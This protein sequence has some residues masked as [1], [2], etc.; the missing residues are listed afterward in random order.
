MLKHL[1]RLRLPR[2]FP[3]GGAPSGS[4]IS[5]IF[6]F[7]PAKQKR[8]IQIYITN[9]KEICQLIARLYICSAVTSKHFASFIFLV[10][11][12]PLSQ[13]PTDAPHSSHRPWSPLDWTASD[14][15]VRGGSSQSYFD[16]SPF[17][18]TA[19]FRGNLDIST[20]GGAGFASQRTT[21]EHRVWDLSDYDGLLLDIEKTDGKRYTITIKDELLEKSPN[22]R[23]QSTISWEFDFKGEGKQE[24]FIPWGKLKATYRGR[25]DKDA[26]NLDLKSVKRISL[27]MRR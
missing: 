9:C 10:H 19:V 16:C 4:M 11:L 24:L 26:K 1:V 5:C 7:F 22:G 6:L 15:R 20:L 2:L 27:M 13:N 18:T 21:G 14:D 23:E 12:L 25:E 17:Q 8:P 3:V